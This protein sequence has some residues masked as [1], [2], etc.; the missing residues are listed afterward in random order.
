MP[1]STINEFGNPILNEKKYLVIWVFLSLTT[2][3]SCY[4]TLCV[5]IF[6]QKM[7]IITMLFNDNLGNLDGHDILLLHLSEPLFIINYLLG[8]LKINKEEHFNF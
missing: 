6:L 3:K 8:T 4:L 7:P 5:G 2:V 1:T